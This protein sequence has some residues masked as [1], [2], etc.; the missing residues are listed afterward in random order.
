MCFHLI[1]GTPLIPPLPS[2][3]T[4]LPLCEADYDMLEVTTDMPFWRGRF[5]LDQPTD[6]MI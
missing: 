2:T 4:L 5:G 3:N 1:T 6:E